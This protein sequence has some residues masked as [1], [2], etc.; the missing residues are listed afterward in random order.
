[1]LDGDKLPERDGDRL[2]V[3]P[4]VQPGACSVAD[5]SVADPSVVASSIVAAE[6]PDDG[7][8]AEMSGAV[9]D[10]QRATAVLPRTTEA[11]GGSPLDGLSPDGLPVD[12]LPADGSPADGSPVDGSP[13]D[14]AERRLVLWLVGSGLVLIVVL[15]VAIVALWPGGDAGSPSALPGNRIRPDG[16][17]AAATPTAPVGSAPAAPGASAYPVA[18]PSPGSVA[19][20]AP[21]GSIPGA[22]PVAVP[23]PPAVTPSG[24]PAPP[25][26]VDRVGAIVG[27]GGHCLDVSGGIS[28]LGVTV[29]LL[30]TAVSVYDCDGTQTQNWTFA[31]DGTLRV[32]GSCAAPDGSVVRLTGCA[33]SAQWR[34]GPGDTLVDLGTGRCLTDPSGGA[35][36]GGPITVTGCGAAG[37]R[38]L[39]P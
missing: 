32:A 23:P 20:S 39:L 30:G 24:T 28:L 1:M 38:W 3:R 2:L 27:A 11:L 16:G 8:L 13:V 37:Q 9:R 29:S 21:A 25:P 35:T 6:E 4:Y 33:G 17:P 18:P 34:A 19:T 26:A 31:T 12:G 22:P 36:T 5:P 10:G 14:G 15:A 7:G